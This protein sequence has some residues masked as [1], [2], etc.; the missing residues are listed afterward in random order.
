MTNVQLIQ[1]S[2]RCELGEG[3]LYSARE[4]AFFWADILG[5]RLHRLALD[6]GNIR[7][8]S[9]PEKICWIIERKDN[10]GFIA[11]MQS[12]IG[13]LTLNP[14]SWKVRV[15]PEPDLPENRMNDAKAD[16]AGRIW[17]GTMHA[18][19]H[20]SSGSLYR[21]DPNWQITRADTDYFI[22]NGP[23][24]ARNQGYLYHT[25]S[26]RRLIYRFR[27]DQ[28]GWLRDREIFLRFSQ[29]DGVPD[30]MTIDTEGGLWVA[31]WGASR[32]VRFAASGALDCTFRLPASQPTS[33][34]FGGPAFDRLFVTSAKI[35]LSGEPGAGALF[36]IDS[37]F[38]GYPAAQFAG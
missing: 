15:I 29:E 27:L 6:D 20:K 24:I 17:A 18:D 23:A 21:L 1:L 13:I 30:G 25:D 26:G 16:A 28:D 7:S 19:G 3:P 31:M 36:E 5:Q 22:A 8:W 35:G 2:P 33:C 11:G 32:V 10:A 34:A 14:F 4:N 38:L 12:S 9:M 37:G